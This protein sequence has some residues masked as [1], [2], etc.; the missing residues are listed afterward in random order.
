MKRELVNETV[1]FDAEIKIY[2]PIWAKNVSYQKDSPDER[3][4]W[5][6]VLKKGV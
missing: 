4:S 5:I 6:S 1:N 3:T 2:Q